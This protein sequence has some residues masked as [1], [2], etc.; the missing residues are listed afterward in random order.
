MHRTR[1]WLMAGAAV[2]LIAGTAVIAR[3]ASPAFHELTVALP[4][5]GVE[6]IRYSGDV[7]PE[8]VVLP[9]AAVADPL[10]AA[11]APPFDAWHGFAQL[12]QISQALDAE[13]AAQMRA[14]QAQTHAL[15][16]AA[17]S[18]RYDAAFG[19]LPPG[20]VEYTQIS[21]FSGHGVC[22]RTTR[23]ATP[24]G[25]GRPQFVSDVSGDCAGPTRRDDVLIQAKTPA[26]ATRPPHPRTI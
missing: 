21:T 12:Q 23:L 24:A 2:A 14:M 5:G 3:A 20:A 13:M 10:A 1:N 17:Q 25:G 19:T 18:G 11:F 16:A 4:G 7:R 6:H 9:R 22:T 26:P 8:I 15:E